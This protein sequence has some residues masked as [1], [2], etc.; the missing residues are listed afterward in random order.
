[1]ALTQGLREV[2]E[3]PSHPSFLPIENWFCPSKSFRKI[4][5]QLAAIVHAWPVG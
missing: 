3:G 1:M 4:W 5:T 2:R